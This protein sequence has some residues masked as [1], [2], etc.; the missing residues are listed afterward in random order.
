VAENREKLV[1]AAYDLVLAAAAR[2]IGERGRFTLALAGGSTPRPLYQALAATPGIDWNRWLLFFGDERTV[3]PDHAESNF[4][5]VKEAWLDP[6]A[7]A[8][9]SALPH[10]FRMAG[11]EEPVAASH[12]YAKEIQAN[13]P[14][15]LE[16]GTGQRPRFDLILLGMGADG[17]TASLFP[18][19]VALHERRRLV[20]ANP[21][22][23]LATTRLT[24][25]Y[26]ML[27]A[28]RA[29]LFLVSGADKAPALH[30]VLGAVDQRLRFPS[31]GVRPRRGVVT[32]LVDAAAAGGLR[33]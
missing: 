15:T 18:G 25:T 1:Q 24:F 27:N 10:F 7:A 8:G 29:I 33:S 31:Q 20:V 23:Q 5:M 30:A 11:E 14:S 2:A 9:S 4:H 28:A 26:P 22:P 12:A 6:L 3:P 32:W 21:V 19:T 13:V 17:H 16:A